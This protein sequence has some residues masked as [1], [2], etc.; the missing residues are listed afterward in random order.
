MV[1]AF[2]NQWRTGRRDC[3]GVQ[4]GRC[5]A[6]VGEGAHLASSASGRPDDTNATSKLEGSI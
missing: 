5:S 6:S 4:A 2:D 1:K 3:W